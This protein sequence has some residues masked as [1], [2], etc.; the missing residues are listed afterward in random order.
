MYNYEHFSQLLDRV[1]AGK[2]SEESMSAGFKHTE[3][4]LIMAVLAAKLMPMFIKF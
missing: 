3:I 1:G 2:I 4:L